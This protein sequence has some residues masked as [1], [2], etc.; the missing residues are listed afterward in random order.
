MRKRVNDVSREMGLPL[1]VE[2]TFLTYA[3][4]R[5]SEKYPRST[6]HALAAVLC[7]VAREISDRFLARL[8]LSP[9]MVE[10]LGES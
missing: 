9:L 4:W 2:K 8:G 7:P 3:L 5:G 10:R 6:Q 1:S